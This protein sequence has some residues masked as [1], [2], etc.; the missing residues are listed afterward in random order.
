[1]ML[2]AD[3]DEGVAVL[4]MLLAEEVS[5]SASCACVGSERAY[6]IV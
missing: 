4:V 2:L 5:E 6:A 1:M 3:C